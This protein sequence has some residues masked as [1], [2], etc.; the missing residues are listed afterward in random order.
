MWSRLQHESV[1]LLYYAWYGL[2]LK[3][4]RAV[5][6][7]KTSLRSEPGDLYSGISYTVTMTEMI[8]VVAISRRRTGMRTAFAKVAVIGI[9]MVVKK[10]PRTLSLYTPI[11]YSSFHCLFHYPYS[12]RQNKKNMLFY[13]ITVL[14]LSS[15]PNP[16]P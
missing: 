2:Y 13:I 6:Q 4:P 10:K 1:R 7:D 8:V 3:E 9:M 11:Y 5:S 16:E 12:L 14:P 15:S